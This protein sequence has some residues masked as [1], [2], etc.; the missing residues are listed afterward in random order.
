L[1]SANAAKPFSAEWM[2]KR[3]KASIN[4]ADKRYSPAVNVS[5]PINRH[6]EWMGRTPAFADELEKFLSNGKEHLEHH[7]YL[8]SEL[9][10]HEFISASSSR[11]VRLQ[12]K[13]LSN[14][15]PLLIQSGSKPIRYV[16]LKRKSARPLAILEKVDDSLRELLAKRRPDDPISTVQSSTTLKESDANSLRHRVGK[17][18]DFLREAIAIA[19]GLPAHLCNRP[20]LLLL[21]GAGMGKTHLLCDIAESRLKQGYPTLLI[22]GQQLPTA[23]HPIEAIIARLGL[24]LSVDE[25]LDQ[26]DDLAKRKRKRALIIVDAINESD[27]KAWKRHLPNIIAAIERRKHIGIVLSCRSPFEKTTIPDRTQIFRL[28]HQGFQ[29]RELDALWTYFKHYH[30]PLPEI[31]FLPDEFSNPLFL[32]IF[33]ESL[34]KATVRQKHARVKEISSGQE[35]ILNIFEDFVIEKAK[36]V[37]KRFGLN[38]LTIWNIIKEGV[39]AKMAVEARSWLKENE[40]DAILNTYHIELLDRKPLIQ[41]LA[42]E[43]LLTEDVYFDQEGKNHFEIVRLPYQKFSDHLIARNLLK[44]YLNRADPKAS[45]TPGTP[46]GDLVFPISGPR[47]EPGIVEALLA[48]F[49]QWTRNVGEML[50]NAP[51]LDYEIMSLF[52]AGLP[53]RKPQC[54]NSSTQKYI[55]GLVQHKDFQRDALSIL[56]GLG[57]LTVPGF[58]FHDLSTSARFQ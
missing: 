56:V 38:P 8:L 34:E 50:D 35:G 43:G 18:I 20:I 51:R 48:E 3:L 33:C 36:N 31:P 54:F 22:L 42:H 7:E 10:K 32:K 30:I 23:R 41:A 13:G 1:S 45:T 57:V 25:F 37:G 15:L 44:R 39:A 47:K 52:L 19:E 49:P 11:K 9:V 12:L 4:S 14:F 58:T 16:L 40:I 6:F 17:M 26:F 24:T 28:Y 46:L 29:E 2:L 5:L 53:W 21:G 27:R 55:G